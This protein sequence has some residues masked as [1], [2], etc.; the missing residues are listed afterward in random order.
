VCHDSGWLYG[1][2]CT[3]P[4]G[5]VPS[6]YATEASTVCPAR[7]PNAMVGLDAQ[8][9]ESLGQS[10]DPMDAETLLV[11]RWI[12]NMLA[13]IAV[14]EMSAG[15]REYA[16][17]LLADRVMPVGLDTVSELGHELNRRYERRCSY[18]K[19]V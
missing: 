9:S 19:G 12:R 4:A 1:S 11:M 15:V 10:I 3:A 7:K 13:V 6:V 8:E 18:K 16:W 14:G 2:A 17:R 5:Y